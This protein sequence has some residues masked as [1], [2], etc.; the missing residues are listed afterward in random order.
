M[1]LLFAVLLPL[2]LAPP[3]LA[4]EGGPDSVAVLY[5]DYEGPDA[6]LEQLEVGLA[7]MLITDL[8]G[9]EGVT[10]VERARLQ[11]ILDELELGH[12]GI[13]DP[14]TAAKVGRLIGAEWVCTGSYFD[15]L[16]T[17]RVDARVI[18]V[19]TGAVVATGGAQGAQANVLDLERSL[20]KQLRTALTVL[21]A[22][23]DDGSG[24]A[25]APPT[26]AT[27]AAAAVSAP[28]PAATAVVAE[29]PATLDAALAFSEG[30]LLLD[31]DEPTRAR[32]AF[33][34]ALEKDPRLDAA[35]VQLAA[36]DE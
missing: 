33:R 14:S 19:E 36:L 24:A 20:A 15:L 1:R 12:Q 31:R 3:A 35:R 8:T 17:F 28:S 4:R 7:Q 16:G 13:A 29:D 26:A 34:T 6:A 23:D 10:V 27:D 22:Q 9:T 30:L 25:D 2:L 11:A 21:A 5:F 18:D 32:E